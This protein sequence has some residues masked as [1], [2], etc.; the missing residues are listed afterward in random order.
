MTLPAAWDN[1]HQSYVLI[2]LFLFCTFFWCRR[3]TV[4]LL[5]DIPRYILISIVKN[6]IRFTKIYLY[7][8]LPICRS[9][10]A[11]EFVFVGSKKWA[12]TDIFGSNTIAWIY[13]LCVI[14]TLRVYC[15]TLIKE[16]DHSIITLLL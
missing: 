9:Q 2:T 4:N 13:L 10:S 14:F 1:S 12:I 15:H 5:I 8:T 3:Y 11:V 6:N 16:R 7:P